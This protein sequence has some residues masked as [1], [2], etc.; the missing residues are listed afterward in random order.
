MGSGNEPLALYRPVSIHSFLNVLGDM[1][2]EDQL[3]DYAE[4]ANRS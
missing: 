1:I 4:S 3:E 2:R